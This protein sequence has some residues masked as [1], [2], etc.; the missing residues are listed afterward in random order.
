MIMF[1]LLI[2]ISGLIGL[3]FGSFLAN[4]IFRSYQNRSILSESNSICESCNKELSF[5]DNIPILS[6]LLLKGRCRY[7]KVQISKVYPVVEAITAILFIVN[8][9]LLSKYI[10][11][12]SCLGDIQIFIY[13]TITSLIFSF[14]IYFSVYDI[15]FLE[16]NDKVA[17]KYIIFLCFYNLVNMLSGIALLTFSGI[18][19]F[20]AA[21]I[22]TV[23]F[24]IVVI[25]SKGKMGGG[26]IRFAAIVGLILGLK[27]S[28]VGINLGILFA[29]FYGIFLYCK[30]RDL[31]IVRKQKIPLI[32]FLSIGVIVAVYLGEI[33]WSKLF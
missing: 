13:S 4:L 1:I 18:D 25:L 19:N 21:I 24:T 30:H 11:C 7:C 26:E 33:I 31:Q 17:F 6:F 10:L 3:S 22:S 23:I 29:I 9:T 27:A 14:L 32:P 5:L 15:L 28:Y 12:Y 2:L 8:Y 20:L 16:I